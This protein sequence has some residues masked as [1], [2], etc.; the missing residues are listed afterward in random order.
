M[1]SILL[2]Y[3]MDKLAF[4]KF[5]H[6]KVKQ[7]H[8]YVPGRSIIE[9]QKQY[10]IQNV[11]KLASNENPL[12]CSPQ[13]I[14][15]IHQIKAFD[16]SI[17][18]SMA[19]HNL[20]T[21]LCHFLEISKENLLISNGSDAI[22]SML[23]QAYALAYQKKI[24][25]HQY[26]FMG[27]EIQ[28]ASF[29]IETLKA[30]ID[31][32]TWLP[33]IDELIQ[34][35]KNNVALIFLANPNNPTGQKIQ[36]SDID[37]I[38]NHI[39]K[40][41]LLVLDEAYYEYDACVHPKV[42]DLLENHPN[43]IIT[44]TF[45][46]AYGLAALRVGYMLAH[47]EII[48]T[49]KRIQLPFSIN[50]IGLNA[51]DIALRD[52]DFIQQSIQMNAEGMKNLLKE[53]PVLPFKVRPSFGNFITIEYHQDIKYLVDYLESQGIIIRSLHAFG[54]PRVARITI[55]TPIENQRLIKTFKQ[56]F[57]KDEPK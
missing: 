41:T 4:Q 38:L 24:L 17:Y 43:L 34:L 55:G 48:H 47:S 9:I 27:Y 32:Q 50:Q 25:T 21:S 46:K 28:A 22:F 2:A 11:I 8:P 15:N 49:L 42:S 20:Y 54:L 26:A 33:D 5:I 51:A 23:I 30:S 14:E 36:W 1:N 39:P 40:E 6:S 3:T 19:H 44:R 12:G 29:G 56:F 35:S 31:A 52:Q 53:L 10:Q 16:I 37:T 45:S 13:V 57:S 7:L 18:P